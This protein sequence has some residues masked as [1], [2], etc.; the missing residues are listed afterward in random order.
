L[1]RG[2]RTEWEY[3]TAFPMSP[4]L[5]A[6]P[7]NSIRLR[8]DTPFRPDSASPGN[9]QAKVIGCHAGRTTSC[10]GPR[11]LPLPSER[12][13]MFPTLRRAPTLRRLFWIAV[14]QGYHPRFLIRT[15][16]PPIP[17]QTQ[18]HQ[19][20]PRGHTLFP[21][22]R[23]PRRSRVRPRRHLLLPRDRMASRHRLLPAQ[24]GVLRP[25]P[26]Q[27]EN[28]IPPFPILARLRGQ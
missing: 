8:R 6:L 24:A 3:R 25:P 10:P 17:V 4:S 23:P 21:L 22:P 13:T 18:F 2:H 11:L 20:R 16:L 15:L 26:C 19:W 9:P 12:R 14:L 5:R 27:G 28:R 7:T 1:A